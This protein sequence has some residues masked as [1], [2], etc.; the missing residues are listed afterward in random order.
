MSLLLFMPGLINQKIWFSGCDGLEPVASLI[1]VAMSSQPRV[2]VLL[3]QTSVE[4]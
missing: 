4:G 2:R 1:I 3:E